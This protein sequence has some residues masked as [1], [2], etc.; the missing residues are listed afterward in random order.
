MVKLSNNNKRYQRE[1]VLIVLS[2][3]DNDSISVETGLGHLGQP[4]HV[5]SGSSALWKIIQW[6]EM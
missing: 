5:L 4:G 3:S 2:G 6:I 1:W